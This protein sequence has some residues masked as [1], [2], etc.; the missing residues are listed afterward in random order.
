MA[1]RNRGRGP[2]EAELDAELAA[3][4]AES[5]RQRQPMKNERREVVNRASAE[6]NDTRRRPRLKRDTNASE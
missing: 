6:K 2:T 3:A 4:I 1:D 5:R